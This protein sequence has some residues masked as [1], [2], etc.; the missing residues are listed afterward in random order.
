M[1]LPGIIAGQSV[2]QATIGTFMLRATGGGGAS[3]GFIGWGIWPPLFMPNWQWM[4]TLPTPGV[5][6]AS[7]VQAITIFGMAVLVLLFVVLIALL[8]TAT[9]RDRQMQAALDFLILS[10]I[11]SFLFLPSQHEGYW[12][13]AVVLAMVT[14]SVRWS[15]QSGIVLVILGFLL[16]Q[17][18][19]GG[20]VITGTVCEY[21][22][23]AVGL[24][25]IARILKATRFP[26]TLPMRTLIQLH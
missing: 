10:P 20:Q 12:S 9:D 4:P 25:E 15:R 16:I 1:G 6:P 13:L 5:D 21:A 3:G 23:V 7:Q 24:Y 18:Y 14:F 26:Q 19:A 11:V 22:L 2:A 17:M 8:L